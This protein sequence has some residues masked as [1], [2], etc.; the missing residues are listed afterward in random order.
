M[1]LR[2]VLIDN[3]D[4]VV[5]TRLGE[6][7]EGFYGGAEELWKVLGELEKKGTAAGIY[8]GRDRNYV[9]H[10]AFW[11]GLRLSWC[12]IESGGGLFHPIT[13]ELRLNP[14][15]TPEVLEAFAELRGKWVPRILKEFSELF[16]YPGNQIQLTFERKHGVEEP[17][18]RFFQAIKEM[19]EPLEKQGLIVVHASQI[20][21]DIGPVGRNGRPIDKS[22]GVDFYSEVTGIAPEDMLGIGDSRGDLPL[23]SRVP[24]VGCPRDA[25]PPCKEAVAQKGGHIS[26]LPYALGVA[27]VIR[28]FLGS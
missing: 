21:V 18:E 19:L 2:A 20:A 12:I 3:D 9:E 16:E 13:K 5:P 24:R 22:S 4:C 25:T 26:S 11:L 1:P 17:I 15:L 6:M 10:G 27:D 14:M 28:H 7:P 8:T 23:F